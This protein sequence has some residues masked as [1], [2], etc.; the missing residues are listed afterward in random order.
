MNANDR[1][2]ELTLPLLSS[3]GTKWNL[4]TLVSMK[5]QT[6]NR[7]LYFDQIYREI[8][9]LPGVI[10]EF[11][12]QWGATTSQL[13]NLRG[14]HEPYNYAR[15]I[16]SFDTFD[17]FATVDQKDGTES[18]VGD[19]STF[20]GYEEVLEEILSIHESFLQFPT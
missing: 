3:F 16:F 15:H 5:R 7:V 2:L 4:H 6:L 1:L 11:G 9:N 8:V 12:V 18:H 17:G 20:Q 19:Y 10:C 13:I 14:L